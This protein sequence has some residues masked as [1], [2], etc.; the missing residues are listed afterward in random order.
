MSYFT[1][2]GI[3]FIFVISL[4]VLLEEDCDVGNW[5]IIRGVC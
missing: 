4:E 1:K 3:H 2:I 5:L